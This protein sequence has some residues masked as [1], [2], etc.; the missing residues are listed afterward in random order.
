MQSAPSPKKAA[1]EAKG[2]ARE[3]RLK[4]LAKEK[5]KANVVKTD[6]SKEIFAV[7]IEEHMA[8]V[9]NMIHEEYIAQVVAE[10]KRQR[11]EM[12]GL[13]TARRILEEEVVNLSQDISPLQA[14]Q[15]M[16]S[17]AEKEV[18]KKRKLEE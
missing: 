17:E 7:Q 11:Q 4:E 1:I 8:R 6:D 18:R 13:I 5:G 9:V 12:V 14:Q 15:L 16:L 3:A 10:K 2:Q